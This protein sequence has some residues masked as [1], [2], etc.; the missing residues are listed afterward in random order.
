[1]RK[2][3][4]FFISV[5]LIKYPPSVIVS[6]IL[7]KYTVHFSVKICEILHIHKLNPMPLSCLAWRWRRSG[8]GWGSGTSPR[9]PSP[10]RTWSKR[11]L[12]R[13]YSPVLSFPVYMTPFV[14]ACLFVYISLCLYLS[15]CAC[16]FVGHTWSTDLLIRVHCIR[17]SPC[18]LLSVL[19]PFNLAGYLPSYLPGYLPGYLPAWLHAWLHTRS[20]LN[21]AS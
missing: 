7:L 5:L 6:F 8:W 9:S 17:Q 16:A 2:I 20:L 10:T 21:L 4:F 15:S 18:P 1:M 19:V 14:L 13:Y 12:K 11:L 3:W